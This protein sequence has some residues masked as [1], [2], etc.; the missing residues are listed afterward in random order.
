LTTS[1]RKQQGGIYTGFV[2]FW[3]YAGLAIVVTWPL[4][5]Q[6]HTHLPGISDDKLIHYWNSWWV[7][8]AFSSGQ[9]PFYTRYLFYPMGVSLA[10][11][12]IA[13]FNVL[14]WLLLEPIVG[15]VKAYNLALLLNLTLCGYTFFWFAKELTGDS[16]AAFLAGVIYQTWPF[17]LTQLD[18]PNLLSTLWVPVFFLFLIR[19]IRQGHWRDTWLT[20]LSFALVG[21]TRWQQLIPVTITG[22]VYFA[23]AAPHWLPR[24]KRH[25]LLR[26]V[27]AGCVAVV[28]LTP[29]ILLLASHTDNELNLIRESEE[30]M[31]QTDILAYITPS[32]SHRLLGKYTEPLYDRYYH[33]R[34]GGRR[35]TTYIGF[36]P[37]L[38]ALAGALTK[39]WGGLSWGL[40]AIILILLALGPLL[41]INGRLY[42]RVPTL[43]GLLS[44]IGV[45]R[46]MREPDRFNVFLALPVSVLAAYGM[47]A[48]LSRMR[49][50][51][52]RLPVF[53]TM[54][55][56][57]LILLEY[58]AI[59]AGLTP[60]PRFPSF[61][62]QLAE[63]PGDFAVLNLP[64]DP[65]IAKRYM[66]AQTVHGHPM[67]EGH[68]SRR[69]A[70]ATA[71]L[72]THPMLRSLRQTEEID[73]RLTDV[74]RQMQTLQDAGFRY[75]IVHKDLI[76]ADRVYHWRRYL[77]TKPRF[78]DGQI[79]VHAIVPLA[80][81]DFE[82]VE[83]LVSGIGPVRVITSTS[84]LNPGRTMSVD[85]GW[86]T[87]AAPAQDLYVE[88]AL[89]TDRGIAHH[90]PAVPVSSGWSTREWP[91]NALAWGY[92]VLHV[93]P[94]LPADIY[95]IRLALV[96]PATGT[97]KGQRFTL[98]QVTVTEPP[99][100]LQVP[101]DAVGVNAVFGDQL[102][103]LGYQLHRDGDH[104]RLVL[105]WRAER[106]MDSDYT[107]F[108]HVFDPATAIPVAQDDSMPHRGALPTRLWGSGEAVRDVIPV[109]LDGVPDGDYGVA[110]GVYDATTMERLPVVDATGQPRP[111]GR[112]VLAGETISVAGHGP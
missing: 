48:V 29:A 83:E 23:C 30:T 12:N 73:P 62:E 96:D 60:V 61:Y 20:G 67:V 52:W 34:S 89:A 53:V 18:H 68:V 76:G 39:R 22:L 108:V 13:W 109:F 64:F 90:E 40:M 111:D 11:H 27:A 2:V 3:I 112:L 33:D 7:Q 88:L 50:R 31:R 102:R 80:G 6:M 74:S 72:D 99:C 87:K 56:S 25:V 16:R 43:Y 15:S 104:L 24:N 44:P 1:R 106:R 19:T 92:Y 105:H 82:L 5:I 38:L 110:V 71:F 54:L 66:L 42:P 57:G 4:A 78:E 55:L 84:C 107:I 93:P 100:V 91:A 14:P 10:T 21:Y 9:S 63:E 47:Q 101:P 35:V 45:I 37:L 49:W 65:L 51:T 86:G 98:G 77:L 70:E 97:R 75:I 41:R 79:A 36:V 8:Q 58:L 46:L 95:D 69:P 103:L 28:L 32:G 26:L 94:S 59:P 85:I 81:R 17:R